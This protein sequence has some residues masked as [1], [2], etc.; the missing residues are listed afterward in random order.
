LA[1]AGRWDQRLLLGEIERHAFAAIV[2]FTIAD[3]PLHRERWTDEMLEVIGRRYAVAERVG[4]TLVFR[5]RLE[6]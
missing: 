2:I 3:I 5:P 1:R 4:Q 6:R